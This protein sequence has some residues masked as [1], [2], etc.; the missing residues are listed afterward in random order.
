MDL[1]KDTI[2]LAER[3]GVTEE[4]IRSIN[5]SWRWWLKV[6]AGQIGNPGVNHVLALRRMAEDKLLKAR[7]DAAA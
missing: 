2:T 5:L 4:D 7:Q 3:V 1:L 6:K